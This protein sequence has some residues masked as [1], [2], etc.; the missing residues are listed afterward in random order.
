LRGQQDEQ[1]DDE[2]HANPP[3]IIGDAATCGFFNPV[4]AKSCGRDR[5]DLVLT[6]F[7]NGPPPCY[8]A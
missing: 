7:R 2:I 8:G 4:R 6:A 3:L 5:G 1:M